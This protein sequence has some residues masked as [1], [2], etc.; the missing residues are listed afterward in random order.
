MTIGKRSQSIA[1]MNH[2][3]ICRWFSLCQINKNYHSYNQQHHF[4]YGRYLSYNIRKRKQEL[5]SKL[6]QQIFF[7]SSFLSRLTRFIPT[8]WCLQLVWSLSPKNFQ[9][10]R[11][12]GLIN[13]I[14]HYFFFWNQ[15]FFKYYASNSCK[16][17][18]S[19]EWFLVAPGHFTN[20]RAVVHFR[21]TNWGNCCKNIE[22]ELL[23]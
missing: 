16:F 21:F 23:F 6:V 7:F 11:Q 13:T 8:N 5:A 15:R 20:V 9:L 22:D 19:H 3:I 1:L 12:F 18:F 10:L 17:R 2:N 4:G 14:Q